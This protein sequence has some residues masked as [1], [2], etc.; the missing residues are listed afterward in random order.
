MWPP[1]DDE[2]MDLPPPKSQASQPSARL[3]SDDERDALDV[4]CSIAPDLSDDR[5]E[6]ENAPTQDAEQATGSENENEIDKQEVQIKSVVASVPSSTSSVRLKPSTNEKLVADTSIVSGASQ[7]EESLL[8]SQSVIL[9]EKKHIQIL[10]PDSDI[11]MAGS[12]SQSQN[13]QSLSLSL[14]QSQ[15]HPQP[16]PFATPAPR[17]LVADSS[18]SQSQS[19]Q[20]SQ[21][22]KSSKTESDSQP[23]ESLSIA[24][25]T[26]RSPVVGSLSTTRLQHKNAVAGPSKVLLSQDMYVSRASSGSAWRR[27]SKNGSTPEPGQQ[28][29]KGSVIEV[30]KACAIYT[31]A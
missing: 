6:N 21:T 14:S 13:I 12:Q 30:S 25:N 3:D 8:L 7:H 28:L 4:Q 18:Q 31:K 22:T 27:T 24:N 26:Y 23:N 17:V 9:H 5:E 16:I 19:Q 15:S 10:V 11:S 1:S 20:D 29:V 2:E